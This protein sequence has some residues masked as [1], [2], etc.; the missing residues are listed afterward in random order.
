MLI[1]ISWSEFKTFITDSNLK[2]IYVN[3]PNSS[4]YSVYASYNGFTLKSYLK[5]T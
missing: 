4:N 2:W 1:E 3:E 5:S